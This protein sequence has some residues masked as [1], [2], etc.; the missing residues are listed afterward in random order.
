NQVV[1]ALSVDYRLV[2]VTVLRDGR[3]LDQ[4]MGAR[5]RGEDRL[6]AIVALSDLERLLR[7]QPSSAEFA[8][9]VTGFLL[10]ARG[11]LAGLVR[12]TR[13]SS[14]GGAEQAPDR[15]PFRLADSLTRGQAED[16]L[17]QLA[18]ERV[19]ARLVPAGSAVGGTNGGS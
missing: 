10:P 11:W 6:V 16:L 9:D 17:I 13:P 5:L 15:L 19:Q 14:A 1:R 12:P 4:P 8:V 3:M 7:R 2:P 18:R